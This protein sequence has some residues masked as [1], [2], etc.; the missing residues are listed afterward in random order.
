MPDM[1][2]ERKY[3]PGEC[4]GISKRRVIGKGALHDLVQFPAYQ[5]RRAYD[6]CHGLAALSSALGALAVLAAQATQRA[7]AQWRW[8]RA[9]YSLRPSVEII[10]R[11]VQPW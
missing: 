7:Q 1:T 4:C 2:G 8:P 9:D 6:A 10:D 3:S 5:Q 11:M